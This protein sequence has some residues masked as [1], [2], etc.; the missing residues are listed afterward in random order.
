MAE[1]VRIYSFV[2]LSFLNLSYFFGPH[3]LVIDIFSSQLPH[4]A[5]SYAAVNALVTLGGD[6]ALSSINRWCNLFV[7]DRYLFSK[8]QLMLPVGDL[9]VNYHFSE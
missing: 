4:L 6:R 2:S 9:R 5:T 7:Y 3:P 8:R 1:E